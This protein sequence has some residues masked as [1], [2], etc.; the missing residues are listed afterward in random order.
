MAFWRGYAGWAPLPPETE[1][2]YESRPLTGHLDIEFDIGPSCYNFVDVRYIGEPVLRSRI[3][4]YEQNVTYITQTVNVTNITYKNKTVYNYGPD[5]N[6]VNQF[7]SRPIQKLKL[8]RQ[9]NVDVA[10]AANPAV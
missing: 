7:S 10:T 2:V 5:L 3:V 4:A 1:V 8:K 9:A 6:T